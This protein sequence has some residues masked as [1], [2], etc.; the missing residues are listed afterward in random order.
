MPKDTGFTP[1]A[2]G[3]DIIAIALPGLLAPRKTLPAKLF[4]DEEGCRLFYQ[5][6]ELPEYYLTRTERT[7]LE[8]VAPELAVRVRSP[9]VLVEYGASDEGKALYLLRQNFRQGRRMVT[10]YVPIDVATP[11]LHSMR[12]RLRTAIPDLGVYP[13]A[14][15]FTEPVALPDAVRG[16]APLGFFPG[17]TIG[18]L[19]PPAARGF[20][21]AARRTLGAEGLFLVGA[22]LR[23]SPDVLLPAYDDAAGITAAFNR[24]ILVRL[25]REA[26]A[27]FQPE[28]FAHRAIWNNQES[29][30]EMHLLSQRDQTVQLAGHAICFRAGETIHTENSYKLAPDRFKALAMAAGW[31]CQ[32]MWTDREQRFALYLLRPAV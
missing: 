21:T 31:K 11:A 15:D 19:D 23:K 13:I 18:N 22:D 14:A 28:L 26:G 2:A 32:D 30:I 4:Y 16:T 3:A 17:S 9:V 20:L 6:T 10:A 12:A 25:N 1:S 8:Q 7:L 24:N 29:R 27:N 5:I